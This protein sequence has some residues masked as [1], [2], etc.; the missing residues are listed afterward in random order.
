MYLIGAW[1]SLVARLLWE[2]EVVGSNPI[3]PTKTLFL[4]ISVDTMNFSFFLNFLD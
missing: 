4:I 3:A 2:Q 1:R